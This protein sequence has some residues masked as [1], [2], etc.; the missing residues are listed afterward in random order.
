MSEEISLFVLEE[1]KNS[2]VKVAFLLNYLLY[3]W[4]SFG[5]VS[6]SRLLFFLWLCEVVF[7]VDSEVPVLIL[8]VQGTLCLF[9]FGS[10]AA[11]NAPNQIGIQ[12]SSCWALIGHTEFETEGLSVSGLLIVPG[13]IVL[14]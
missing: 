10:I 3:L 4:F 9:S 8:D 2:Q 5:R 12:E 7:C 1:S 11:W 14:D 6:F 13:E